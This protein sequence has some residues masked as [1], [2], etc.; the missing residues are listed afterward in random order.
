MVAGHLLYF[1][2][3]ALHRPFLSFVLKGIGCEE[4][5][6]LPLTAI[7]MRTKPVS[8]DAYLKEF[9]GEVREALDNIR[10]TI[11]RTIPDAVESISYGIPVYLINGTYAIYFAGFK[12]HV[13]VYPIPPGSE[14]FMKKIAPYRKGKGTLRFSLDNALPLTVISAVAKNGKKAALARTAKRKR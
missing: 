2:L 7:T 13:S 5:G 12:N 3:V 14:A 9:S 8:V 10:S 4:D 6:K 11:R 1:A